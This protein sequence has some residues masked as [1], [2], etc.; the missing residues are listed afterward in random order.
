[1]RATFGWRDVPSYGQVAVWGLGVEGHANLRRLNAL[2]ITPLLVD[3][4]PQNDTVT[5]TSRGGFELLAGCDLVIKTP[6]IS[7]YRDDVREL[8][9][10]KVPVVGGLGLWLHDAPLD[11][12]LCVTGTKGKSTTVSIAGHLAS[13]LGART[14]V[15]GNIGAPPHDP[16]APSDFD[17]W[18][19]EVSSYQATDVGVTPPVVAVTSLNPDHLDWHRSV[20][21]YYRDKLSLVTQPGAELTICGDDPVLR[22][23]SI[24]LGPKVRWV[25]ADD[26]VNWSRGLDLV[27]RHN[28]TNAAVAAAALAAIGVEGADDESLLREAAKGYEALDSRLR[29]IAAA[30]RVEFYDDSLSTNVLPTIAAVE[31]F[32]G[33]RVAVILG[34]FDRGIDYAPLA[35]YLSARPAPTLA[36]TVP[37]SGDRIAD[38]LDGVVSPH[39]KVTRCADV[40]TA[41]KRGRDWCDPD[42]VVL[43]SPAA[44]SFGQFSDYRARAQAFIEAARSCGAK[45]GSQV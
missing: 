3:D 19:I 2:G 7:R 35:D 38:I 39:L 41:T 24:Q 12:V 8:E 33:R 1:M 15:G 25:S 34:G 21:A 14:F 29:R 5:A 42:G 30:G 4:N 6:G 20:D 16:D 11:R 23:H 9:A 44:P 31:S 45:V 22:E 26:A 36:L 18:I 13:R 40:A 28:D 37:A 17:V 43:L 27:G 10:N 32:P